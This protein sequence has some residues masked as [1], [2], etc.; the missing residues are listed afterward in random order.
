[1]SG[2]YSEELKVKSLELR[3]SLKVLGRAKRHSRA[4]GVQEVQGAQKVQ[5]IELAPNSPVVALNI[6]AWSVAY[7]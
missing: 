5:E 6:P 7:S 2:G 1:M 4:Q 3:D